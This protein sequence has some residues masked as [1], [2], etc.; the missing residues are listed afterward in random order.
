MRGLMMDGR[1]TLTAILDR[2]Q[3]LAARKEIVSRLADRSLHRYTYAD[4]AV[5]AKRLAAALG[6]LGVEPG[7]RVATLMWN[8]YRHLEA[9]FGVP[10]A[11]AV[12]HTLNLRL[13]PDDLAYIMNHAEDRVLIV[14]ENLLPLYEAVRD[15]VNPDHVVVAREGEEPAPEGM[16]DYEEL[17]ASVE[18]SD[19]TPPDLDERDAAAM[20]YTSGTTGRPKGV[21]YSHR[22]LALHSLMHLAADTL[23]VSERDT[24]LPVVPMFHANA[25]GLPFS[26]ALAGSKQVMPGPHLDP[27]SLLELFQDEDVTITAGV[28]TIWLGILQT[29]DK[30]PERY[31]L[32]KLRAMLVGGSAPPESLIRAFRE[33][34]GLTV[35]QGWGMTETSPLA[36][37]A[38][39]TSEVL[40]EDA[41]TIYR[42]RAKQGYPV[43]FVEVRLRGEDGLA[44]WDGETM[45]EIE[46]RGPWVASSYYESPDSADKFAEDGWLKTG[47][48]ATVDE[49]G[50][51]EL[52]DRTKD[53][54]KSGGEWISSVALENALM[55]HDAVAEAAVIATP[56][57]RWGERPL[58]CVVFKEGRSATPEELREHLAKSFASWQLPD[59]YRVIEEIPKTSVG[60]FKKTE[61]R[62]RFAGTSPEV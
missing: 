52:K 7:D 61:L 22:S 9:Y 53:L 17:L 16:L 57:E 56:D 59:S 31:D 47:D 60:K 46:L 62:E 13:H 33:R 39:L 21:L 44:P 38:S 36:T 12:L 55:G 8:G 35:L 42:Y 11:G 45:G 26:S 34:H 37:T 49:R 10:A 2:A 41:D 1:L 29:L 51:I 27:E 14:D 25:W 15:R 18:E 6:S 58:A 20:C 43:P 3:K 28:P 54:I 19:F 5:R 40:A 23:A 48:I 50:Y 24:T 4:F 30:E 32:S